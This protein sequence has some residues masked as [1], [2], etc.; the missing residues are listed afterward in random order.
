MRS[1]FAATVIALALG[2]MNFSAPNGAQAQTRATDAADPY[3]WLEEATSP[4]AM[5]WVNTHNAKATAV[6]EADAR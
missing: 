1:I 3:I 6:L 4:R 5:D 2:A